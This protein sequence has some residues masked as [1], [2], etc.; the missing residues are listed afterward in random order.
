MREIVRHEPGTFCWPELATTDA[1]SAKALYG[2]LFGWAF[3]DQ[4]ATAG[5]TYTIARLAGRDVAALYA[6]QR[7]QRV[8]GALRPLEL[9]RSRR[10]RRRER[11]TG[12]GA[13]RND[14]RGALRRREERAHGDREGPAGRDP[15]PV[16]GARASGRADRRR[17]RLPVLD[18]ARDDRH[19]R[20]GPLLREPL[21]LGAEEAGD[22][23]ARLHRA[24]EGATARG[25]DDGDR[26]ESRA[27]RA[28]MGQCISA[29]PTATRPWRRR[30]RSERVSSGDPT[31]SR[32]WGV[33]PSWPTAKARHSP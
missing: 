25:R 27:R 33:T 6:L 21:R 20:R 14:L 13:R 3:D 22:G 26:E 15:V 10:E 23:R 1:E 8:G 32:K 12:E 17:D 24:L 31:T 9:V 19:G 7:S 28:G 11:L 18:R 4:S 2:G 5:T 16:G 30:R 29:W